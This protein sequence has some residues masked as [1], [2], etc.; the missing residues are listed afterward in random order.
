MPVEHIREEE[1][2]ET[3]QESIKR[4]EARRFAP[5]CRCGLDRWGRAGSTPDSLGTLVSRVL[6]HA[7][8]LPTA[9]LVLC[10]T[11]L[12]L[13]YS[14][15]ATVNDNDALKRRASSF[16]KLA[17]RLLGF[18]LHVHSSHSESY[19]TAHARAPVLVASHVSW[20]DV[21]A[22]NAANGAGFIAKASISR[23]PIVGSIARAMGCA[24]VDRQCSGASDAVRH[25]VASRDP[26]HPLVIFPEGTTTNGKYLL[27]FHRGAFLA[28]KP[29]QPVSVRYSGYDS[30]SPSWET[31][32]IRN[33]LFG[34]LANTRADVHVT[35]LP[36]YEPSDAECE[37]PGLYAANIRTIIA[38]ASQPPLQLSDSTYEDK[39]EYHQRLRSAKLA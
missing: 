24:F 28:G 17:L 39:R 34:I 2:R 32:S 27:P 16:S 37:D 4:E 36:L 3:E 21:L 19:H 12:L 7:S 5:F 8:L 31:C 13:F 38:N 26:D 15:A 30:F 18:R 14:L 25:E 9:R 11:L 1:R 20:I 29:V 23:I 10:A 22:L 6:R 33:H 35:M